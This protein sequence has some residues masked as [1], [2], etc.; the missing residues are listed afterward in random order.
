MQ[1]YFGVEE[2]A[3]MD[4]IKDLIICSLA[5]CPL[6]TVDSSVITIN[7]QPICHLFIPQSH[8]PLVGLAEWQVIRTNCR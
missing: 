5:L 4:I 6:I 7:R 3:A 8:Q 2:I 1:R